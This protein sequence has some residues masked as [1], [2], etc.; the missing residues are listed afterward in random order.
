MSK[1]NIQPFNYKIIKNLIFY[2]LTTEYFLKIVFKCVIK[3]LTSTL[4]TQCQHCVISAIPVSHPN[5]CIVRL[6]ESNVSANGCENY[7]F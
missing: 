6:F 7:V 3:K 2:A 4:L 5:L 1:R